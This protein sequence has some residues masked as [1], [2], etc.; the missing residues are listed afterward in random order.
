MRTCKILILVIVFG[1]IYSCSK[2]EE[3]FVVKYTSDMDTQ[4]GW[5]DNP[6]PHLIKSP[7]A[8]SGNYICRLDSVHPYSPTYN[9][10]VSDISREKFSKL[11]LRTWIKAES[12][13]A[14]PHLVLDIRNSNNET[15][16]WLAK[17]FTGPVLNTKDWEM[18]EFEVD[19]TEKERLK[20][21]N[22]YRI[23][24]SN[25]KADAV[26]CDDIEVIFY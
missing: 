24:V 23:Y 17:D 16:E 19:L 4:I 9:M 5:T 12:I 22:I 1:T 2:K 25:G 3:K 7:N 20:E 26:L 8:H 6:L 11:K 18:Y 21:S 15:L 10:H 14:H 13:V